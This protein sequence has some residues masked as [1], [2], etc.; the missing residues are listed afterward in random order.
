MPSI[1]AGV[2]KS[3]LNGNSAWDDNTNKRAMASWMA[4]LTWNDVFLEGNSLGHAVVSPSS[5]TR[6]NAVT[7]PMVATPWNSGTASR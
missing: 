1:S 3:Y 4:G 5:S 6:L 2:G 7:W